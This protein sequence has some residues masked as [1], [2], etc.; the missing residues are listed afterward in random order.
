MKQFYDT[1]SENVKLS[2]LSREITWTNNVI[3]MMAAKTDEG[4]IDDE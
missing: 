2:P 4:L 3:I 1:Y